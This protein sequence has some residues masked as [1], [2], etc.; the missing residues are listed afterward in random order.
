[1]VKLKLFGNDQPDPLREIQIAYLQEQLRQARLTFDLSTAAVAFSIS[2]SVVGAALLFSGRTSEGAVTGA[3][4]LIST[5]FCA[6]IA[7]DATDKLERLAK[8]LKSIHPTPD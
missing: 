4:G 5:T 1:M 3:S 7:K 6:Q 8:D 2:I